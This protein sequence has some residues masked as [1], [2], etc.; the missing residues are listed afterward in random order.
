MTEIKYKYNQVTCR[1]EPIVIT[2]KQLSHRFL[3]FL[4]VSFLL[5][6]GGFIYALVQ[7]PPLDET[8]QAQKN[9]R[10]KAEWQAIYNQIERESERLLALEKNDDE[11]FR[12]ILD[13][14]PL[15]PSQREAGVGGREKESANIIYPFIK[16]SYERT[17]KMINRLEIQEQSMMQLKKVLQNKIVLSAVKLIIVLLS[18]Y[19]IYSELHSNDQLNWGKFFELLERKWSISGLL[20]LLSFSVANRY[21][22]IL[23]WQ[24]LATVIHPITVG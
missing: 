15:S 17:E 4:V 7:L 2:P 22:E 13:L 24:N 20:F 12:M 19:F 14:E 5:G 3:R 11:N 18:F 23:K 9:Q 10:L 6:L 8:A 1:Y 21:L 16:K